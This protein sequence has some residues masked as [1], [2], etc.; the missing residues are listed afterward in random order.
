LR[1]CALAPDLIAA[2]RITEAVVRLGA[3]FKRLD[4][5]GA[6]PP[7]NTVDLLI[8][9]WGLRDANWGD[10]ISR[11]HSSSP[12]VRIILF[13][14]HKDIDAHRSA[15]LDRLG[16]VMARSTF[17]RRLDDLLAHAM[18]AAAGN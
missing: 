2:S 16:P 9:D 12:R 14:P 7:A 13:G 4:S 11:W 5:I 17:F 6:L 15:A 10:R 8:V 3:D 1:V 18:R